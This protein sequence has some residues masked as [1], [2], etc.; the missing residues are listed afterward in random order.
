MPQK[1][2]SDVMQDVFEGQ[3]SRFRCLPYEKRN[4]DED[5]DSEY[6]EYDYRIRGRMFENPE[7]NQISKVPTTGVDEHVRTILTYF[8]DGSRRVF[9]FSDVILP[10]GRY[11]PVLAGQ[12]G[13]A[14]LKRAD[15][16]SIGPLRKYVQYEN[17][18]VFPD[19]IDQSDQN[20]LRTELAN[21]NLQFAV[22][23]YPTGP[24]GG[25][26]NED[27]ISIGTKKILD[28]MHD[29]ELDAVRRMM[30]ARDLHD[31][32]M[33]VVDGSLQFRR[34][35]LRRNDFPI[36]QLANAIGISKSFTPSQ[37]VI[38]ARGSKHLGTYLQTLE[39]GQRTP[40]FKAGHDEFED[41][42]GVW[43]LRIRPKRMM[44]NPLAGIIKIEVL[45]N[46]DE[47]EN[48]LDRDRVDH[49]SALILSERNVT[50][51]GSDNR[52]ANHI[53]PIYLTELYLKSGFLSDVYFKGLL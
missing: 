17:M 36:T 38:G 25:N 15:D 52:W 9:R 24:T 3:G 47:Q 10:D 19:T 44:T 2:V 5:P 23:T 4:L 53:Y 29:L 39:Y 8:M 18:L 51:Y 11:Y 30:A 34:E 13:V 45:A 43:Y 42:L 14:V 20:A 35:V 50:P 32:S 37:P 46:G 31:D 49:L 16:R 41:V 6:R 21:R 48:G 22:A 12:V 26:Q 28:L 1:T 33:L 40:V 27:Y 7:S